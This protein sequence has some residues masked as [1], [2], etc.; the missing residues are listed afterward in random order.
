MLLFKRSG[1][2][3]AGIILMATI[4]MLNGKAQGELTFVPSLEPT[5]PT[6]ET[7]SVRIENQPEVE[8]AEPEVEAAQPNDSE[9]NSQYDIFGRVGNHLSFRVPGTS[10]SCSIYSGYLPPGIELEGCRLHGTPQQAGT[11]TPE[12]Y[13]NKFVISVNIFIEE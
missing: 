3:V 6:V 1:S 5:L 13:V 2:L 11:W 7:P 4:I 10:D 8:S 12:L 9:G